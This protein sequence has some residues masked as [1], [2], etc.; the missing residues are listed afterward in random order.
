M[1][2]LVL[3]YELLSRGNETQKNL[4]S[5]N[6]NIVD[7]QAQAS[8]FYRKVI[9]WSSLNRNCFIQFEGR[10]PPL[11]FN[12]NKEEKLALQIIQPCCI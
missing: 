6:A 7:T 3:F 2:V 12:H 4:I 1:F 10:D 9:L 8:N 5:A 11:W